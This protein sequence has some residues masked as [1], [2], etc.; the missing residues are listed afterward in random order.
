MCFK[1]ELQELK[2]SD[3]ILFYEMTGDST[4]SSASESHGCLYIVA[5]VVVI[6]ALILPYLMILGHA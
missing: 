3:P 6:V 5:F 1:K 2:K 4:H